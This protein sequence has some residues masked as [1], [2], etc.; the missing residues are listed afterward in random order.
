MGLGLSDDITVMAN[1]RA[2][3]VNFIKKGIEKRVK[4]HLMDTCGQ[5]RYQAALPGM[6]YRGAHA[7]LVVFDITDAQ[8]LQGIGARI[9]AFLQYARSDAVLFLVGNKL[10]LVDTDSHSLTCDRLLHE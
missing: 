5:E 2:L 10:D 4:L 8:S 1:L 7:G 9:E 3:P 6:M